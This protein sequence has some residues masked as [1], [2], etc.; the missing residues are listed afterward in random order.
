MD[1][2]ALEKTINA[3]TKRPIYGIISAAAMPASFIAALVLVEIFRRDTMCATPLVLITLGAVVAGALIALVAGSVAIF[4]KRESRIG[5]FLG[6]FGVIAAL[7]TIT[8]ILAR[9]YRR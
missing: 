8:C 5:K 1:T 7:T 2:R 4:C 9:F 3:S 6:S